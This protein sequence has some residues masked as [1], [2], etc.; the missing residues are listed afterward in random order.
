M[1]RISLIVPGIVV[2]EARLWST[3]LSRCND[4]SAVKRQPDV[5]EKY[6]ASV[7]RVSHL[8]TCLH[9][10]PAWQTVFTNFWLHAFDKVREF[11]SQSLFSENA[12]V[13]Q[14]RRVQG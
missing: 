4:G 10:F 3:D 8:A 2:A 1:S 5:S 12:Q 6:I 13:Q 9:R 7:F 11:P 14:Q